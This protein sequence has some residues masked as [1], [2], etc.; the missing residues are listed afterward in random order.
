MIEACCHCGAV[1][2]GADHPPAEV[3]SC[4]CSI[5]HRQGGL[6]AYYTRETARLLSS[7]DAVKAYVWGDRCI[8]FYH[9]TT[10]GCVTHYE[11]TEK[12]PDSRFAINA[13][14]FEP[15]VLGAARIR[16]FDGRDTWQVV[17][18]PL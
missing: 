16:Y 4:N 13:R 2:L 6:W 10:C 3:T 7:A 12:T 17:E 11:S 18:G 14:N 9:C 8:V 15:E 1:R 5:C